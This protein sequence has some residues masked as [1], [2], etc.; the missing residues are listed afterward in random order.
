MGWRCYHVDGDGGDDDGDRCVG[1]H[2]DGVDRDGFPS[3]NSP[4]GQLPEA[5]VWWIFMGWLLVW[6]SSLLHRLRV[7]I[8]VKAGQTHHGTV[9]GTVGTHR[10]MVVICY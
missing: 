3:A 5:R 7:N 6:L 1:L 2:D 4:S 8:L 9:G 10:T